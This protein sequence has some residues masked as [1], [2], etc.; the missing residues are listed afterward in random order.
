MRRDEDG[1]KEMKVLVGDKKNTVRWADISEAPPELV[2]RVL[3]L[4]FE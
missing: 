1:E 4:G 3:A 2:T